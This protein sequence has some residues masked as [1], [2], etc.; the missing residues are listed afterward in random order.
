MS[1]L[2]PH[3]HVSTS[4]ISHSPLS[5]SY[6]YTDRVSTSKG[7]FLV[8]SLLFCALVFTTVYTVSRSSQ[9][10]KTTSRTL[11]ETP[12][13][14]SRG[15]F[16]ILALKLNLDDGMLEESR[17]IRGPPSMRSQ[18]CQPGDHYEL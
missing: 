2:R 9:Q 14:Q 10:I 3:H 8:E 7:I 4:V 6:I 13:M 5:L 18:E 11:E 15:Q 16:A 1:V 12:S 17:V